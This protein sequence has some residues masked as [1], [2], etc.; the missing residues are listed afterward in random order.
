MKKGNQKEMSNQKIQWLDND[1]LIEDRRFCH[2][3]N[4]TQEFYETI[5][6]SQG[7]LLGILRNHGEDIWIAYAT[8]GQ[9][10]RTLTGCSHRTDGTSLIRCFAASY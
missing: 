8:Q 1:I 4:G 6:A 2:G 7:I 3:D 5:I 10:I 9:A